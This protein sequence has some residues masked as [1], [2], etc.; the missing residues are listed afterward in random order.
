MA[1]RVNAISIANNFVKECIQNGIPVKEAILFG[2]YAKGNADENSDV[3]LALIADSFG[4]NII[5]NNRQTALINWH[6]ADVEVHHFSPAEF[7]LDLP[8][9]NEI[10]RTGIKIY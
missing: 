6:Y 9:I 2:S 7:T 3:D 8:F 5:E 10:K 4:K 1:E